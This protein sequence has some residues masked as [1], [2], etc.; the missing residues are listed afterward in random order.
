VNPPGIY[1]G[2]LRHVRH[3]KPRRAFAYRLWMLDIDLDAI[4][5]FAAASRVFCHNRFGLIALHDRDHGPRDGSAL[6]PWV[7][8]ALDDAGLSAFAAR[9][10]LITIPRILGYAFNPISFYVCYDREGRLGAV[11]HQV[12]NTFGDQIGYLIPAPAG[13]PIRQRA[14]K[15]M[16]VS[17]LFDMQGGYEFTL[18]PPGRRFAI[19]IVHGDPAPR[20][21]ASMALIRRPATDAALLRE[22]LRMPL[23]PL[24]IIAA[25]HWQALLTLLR[26]ATFHREPK[27]GHPP[28]V[29]GDPA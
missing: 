12:K 20:L 15:R 14:A 7:E 2:V 5:D 28:I 26:G 18:T 13:S 23:L 10:R 27:D 29:R 6:R 1:A 21:T 8:A 16:H 3:V 22:V 17:P 11:L 25:I 4:D 9:I 19:R 24:K